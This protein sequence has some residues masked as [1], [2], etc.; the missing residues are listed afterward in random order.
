MLLYIWTGLYSKAKLKSFKL[1][2]R[3]QSVTRQVTKKEKQRM[4]MMESNAPHG[5]SH[6]RPLSKNKLT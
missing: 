4:I 6:V 2:C 1:S 3:N 5:D